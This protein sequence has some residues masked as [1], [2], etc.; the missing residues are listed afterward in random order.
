M[1]TIIILLLVINI[2]LT[3]ANNKAINLRPVQTYNDEHIEK[4][5]DFIVKEIRSLRP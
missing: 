2:F 3:L 4:Q 1:E 5:T